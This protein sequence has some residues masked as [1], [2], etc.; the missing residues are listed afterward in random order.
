MRSCGRKRSPI[1]SEKIGTVACA[2][3]AVL[4]SMCCLAPGDEPERERCVEQAEDERTRARRAR[5][6]ATA[7]PRADRGGEIAEQ[8]DAGDQCP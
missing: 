3:A 8:D 7:L 4:E 6:P 5:R 2:I 1:N